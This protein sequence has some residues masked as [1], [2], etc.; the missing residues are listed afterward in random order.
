MSTTLATKASILFQ[1]PAKI[2]D[3][4]RMGRGVIRLI[5]VA[6]ANADLTI[7]HT[8]G[9]MPNLLLVLDPGTNYVDWKRSAITAWTEKSI[10]V[11]F[12]ATGAIKIWI[13]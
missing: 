5:T 8:L 1:F 3:G 11:Q 2:P 10:T 13:V 6:T 9:R 4:F 7:A 12:S